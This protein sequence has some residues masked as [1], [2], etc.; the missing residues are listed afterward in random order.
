LG[1]VGQHVSWV[2][3]PYGKSC[4]V[5]ELL[6]RL[7]DP[8]GRFDR[9]PRRRRMG[10]NASSQGVSNRDTERRRRRVGYCKIYYGF[11][12][13]GGDETLVELR[14]SLYH[15]LTIVPSSCV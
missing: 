3:N 7:A 11:G 12:D 1:F 9:R 2:A 6:H 5:D 13:E 15:S 14:Q 4:C 8:T 10:C